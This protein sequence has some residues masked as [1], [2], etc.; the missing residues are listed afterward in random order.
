LPGR[1]DISAAQEKKREREIHEYSFQS[2]DSV[3]A[4]FKKTKG[5]SKTLLSM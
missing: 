3:E 4:A 5:N 2:L 1:K